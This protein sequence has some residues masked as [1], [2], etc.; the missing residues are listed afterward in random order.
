[1]RGYQKKIIYLKNTG[2]DVFE[3]AYFVLKEQTEQK[4]KGRV[5]LI[6]EANRI[7]DENVNFGFKKTRKINL[8]SVILL[9]TGFILEA[10]ILI[11]VLLFI[12]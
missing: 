5:P 2:S 11:T 6:E 4:I 7:I 12:K 10:A 3:E 9:G 8:K 1:M